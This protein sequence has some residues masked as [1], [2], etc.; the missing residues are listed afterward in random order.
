M[1]RLE[2][3]IALDHRHGDAQQ[4]GRAPRDL[5]AAQPVPEADE[6]GLLGRQRLESQGGS[7]TFLVASDLRPCALLGQEALAVAGEQVAAGPRARDRATPRWFGRA[8]YRCRL[9]RR[10]GSPP[11]ANPPHRT[12]H[13]HRRGGRARRARA[14]TRPPVRHGSP[15]S[16]RPGSHDRASR[17]QGNRCPTASANASPRLPSAMVTARMPSA[18]PSGVPGRR[19]AR[20][21]SARASRSS[22]AAVRSS[23]VSK[24]GAT[25]A[26]SGNRRNSAPHS[27]WMVMMPRPS[28][29]SSTRANSR[30]A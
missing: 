20:S 13:L 26:S 16:W 14:R 19:P 11:R 5:Q 7:A 17:Q 4:G 30:R 9:R 2:S 1:P 23:M 3:L 28:G 6:P 27:A 8:R 29:R 18:R 10:A 15:R 12:R 25:P 24:C 21:T 22:S